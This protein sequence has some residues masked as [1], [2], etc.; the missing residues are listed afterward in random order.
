MFILIL[1]FFAMTS[2]PPGTLVQEGFLTIGECTAAG[3]A[4]QKE[5][6]ERF[7]G[8]LIAHFECVRGV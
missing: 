8:R 6:R 2:P 3:E 4:R 1:S 7:N 5:V